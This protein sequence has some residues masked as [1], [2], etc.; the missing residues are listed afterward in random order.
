[1]NLMTVENISKSFGEKVVL[2]NISFGIETGDKIGIIGVNGTGKSTL[3]KILAGV[4][5]ADD[6]CITKMRGLRI[7]YLPQTPDFDDPEEVVIDYVHRVSI[8]DTEER[9]TEAKTALTRLGITDYY[10]R[11]GELSGGQRKRVAIA[12]AMMSRVDLLILDEPVGQAELNALVLKTVQKY[13]Q[14]APAA[15]NEILKNLP[16][17]QNLKEEGLIMLANKILKEKKDHKEEAR[18]VSEKFILFPN[19]DKYFLTR[20]L[21]QM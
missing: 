4:E 18:K 10:K 9:M 6:G 14:Q 8:L 1:M 11:C 16:V 20:H 15:V 19:I 21:M 13:K 3:L 7:G 5:S 17:K 12:A 2:N